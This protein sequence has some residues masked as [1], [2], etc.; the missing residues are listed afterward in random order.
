[1]TPSGEGGSSCS[2]NREGAR[3][4]ER[5]NGMFVPLPPDVI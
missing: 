3:T 2:P 1:L 4:A 5:P